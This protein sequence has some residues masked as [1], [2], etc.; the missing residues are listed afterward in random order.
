MPWKE[1]I[2][3]SLSRLSEKEQLK[4]LIREAREA[5][6]L[7]VRGERRYDYLRPRILELY[8]NLGLREIF[9]S[10]QTFSW[11]EDVLTLGGAEDVEN[12]ISLVYMEY[13]EEVAK[14]AVVPKIRLEYQIN[15]AVVELLSQNE[16][17]KRD[18]CEQLGK[19]PRLQ[20]RS[21]TT[22]AKKGK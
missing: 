21:S 22:R 17:C 1:R 19:T 18:I 2:E 14:T 7:R 10:P 11:L 4:L 5:K 12:F 9:A 6:S 3:G 16:E 15:P 13:G 20:I 8:A